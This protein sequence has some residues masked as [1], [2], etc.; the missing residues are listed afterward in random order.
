MKRSHFISVVVVL[1]GLLFSHS[2]WA[3]GHGGGGGF[4][5]HGG[6][7]FGGYRGGGISLGYGF[8]YG[9]YGGY[10]GYGGGY[11]GYGYAYPPVIA[12]PATPPVYIQR[13]VAPP[14]EPNYW[15]YCRNAGGYYPYIRD[16]PGGWEKVAPQPPAP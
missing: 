5:G 9:P 6:G 12:V 15:Y 3:H 2:T 1:C 11:G 13:N 16:C 7:G 14:P 4:G 8:G 10:G